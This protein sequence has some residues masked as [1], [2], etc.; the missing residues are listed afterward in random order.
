MTAAVACQR[1]PVAMSSAS[2]S[3]RVAR[4]SRMSRYIAQS[5]LPYL[6]STIRLTASRWAFL[7]SQMATNCTSF[8]GSIQFRSPV[9]R[10]P[11]PMP[12]RMMRSLGGTA[13]LRPSAEAG[14]RQGAAIAPVAA[15]ARFRKPRRVSGA[16]RE[17]ETD[18]FDW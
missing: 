17:V 7:A 6:V 4:N 5:L 16:V 3:V 15:A 8:S 1:S 18:N 11:T 10:L 2:M 12:P 14:M 9:P 13:P